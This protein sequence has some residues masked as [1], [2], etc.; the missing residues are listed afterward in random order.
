VEK[1]SMKYKRL[2]THPMFLIFSAWLAAVVSRLIKNGDVYGLNYNLFHPDGALYHSYT[3]HLLGNSWPES[4]RLV[5]QFFLDQIGTSYLGRTI[6]PAVQ[7]VIVTRPLLSCL[8][9]PFVFLFGQFGMLVIPALSYL[10]IGGVLYLVGKRVNRPYLAVFL[11]FILTLSTSVN[12]WMVS[13]LTD[14]LLVLLISIIYLLLIYSKTRILLLIIVVMALLTRPSGPLLVALLLPFAIS[15]RKVTLYIGIVLSVLGT[16]ALAF[17]SPEAAGTQTTGSYTVYQR[18]QDFAIHAIKILVVEFGQLFVM[19]RVLFVFI[20]L[21]TMVALLTW[22]NV[23][24]QSHLTLL[25]ASFAIGAWNGGIGVNFRYQL[26]TIVAGAIVIIFSADSLKARMSM[27]L[28][29]Q[30]RS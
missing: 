27:L 2:L 22:K 17:V 16:I 1:K 28:R 6:E 25:I 4:A 15:Y 18:I 13:D 14:G 29:T 10:A 24:S 21:S 20:V 26:P 8:S 19:D 11:F 30:I 9:L 5:N 7:M 3:L 12:R 23:Y